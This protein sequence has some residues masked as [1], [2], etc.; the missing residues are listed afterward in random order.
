MTEDIDKLIKRR[1]RKYKR[2]LHLENVTLKIRDNRC[3][4]ARLDYFTKRRHPHELLE[5]SPVIVN[6]PRRQAKE[7]YDVNPLLLD[8]L[9]LHE[10]EHY[11]LLLKGKDANIPDLELAKEVRRLS[12]NEHT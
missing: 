3:P 4:T 1:F 6:I 11:R 9:I 12:R 10:L 2:K 5:G 8:V 7:S